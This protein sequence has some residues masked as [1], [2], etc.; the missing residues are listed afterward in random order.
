LADLAHRPA[1]ALSYGQQKR[2]ALAR[3][4]SAEAKLLLLDEPAAGLDPRAMQDLVGLLRRLAQ[5]GY[6]LFVIEHNRDLVRDLADRVVFLD[7]GRLLR[8]GPPATILDD[9]ELVERYLGV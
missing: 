8:E 1:W 4:L 3:L 7:N 6:T 5:G 2:L 9:R